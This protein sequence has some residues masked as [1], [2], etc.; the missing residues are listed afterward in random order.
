MSLPATSATHLHFE[1]AAPL[2]RAPVALVVA[3]AGHEALQLVVLGGQLQQAVHDHGLA[4]VQQRQ[5]RSYL[6]TD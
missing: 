4:G 6:S 2:T 5:Q 1:G 3:V